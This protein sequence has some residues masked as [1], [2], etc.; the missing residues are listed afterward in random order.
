MSPAILLLAFGVLLQAKPD[1]VTLVPGE[2]TEKIWPVSGSADFPDKTVLQI[3][4]RR[5]ERRWEEGAT[6]PLREIPAETW[7]ARGLA[8][9]IR[10]S[11]QVRLKASTPGWYE[12]AVSR[13][14][15]RIASRLV[16]MGRVDRLFSTTR[17][18]DNAI[19]SVA[20]QTGR[21]LDE[22]ERY[23]KTNTTPPAKAQEDFF[24]RLAAQEQL[25]AVLAAETDLPATITRLQFVLSLLRNA[26]VWG[27]GRGGET[28]E[29]GANDGKSEGSAFHTAKVS[30]D[31]ARAIVTSTRKV[32]SLELRAS[33][34]T[35]LG[36]LILR[37]NTGTKGAER[38][39]LA[40]TEATRLLGE[41]PQPEESFVTLLRA[42]SQ[43]K[44]E[45]LE[46][47]RKSLEI[48]LA[49]ILVTLP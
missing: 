31:E 14:E 11:Y 42:L 8:E 38:L 47:I 16:A 46:G 22:L 13:G 2:P 25:L 18:Q 28:G 43:A 27:G 7:S 41:A 9:V 3:T 37:V 29:A 17:D 45:E 1:P 40:A 21:F 33:S 48:H 20:E 49:T 44:P 10:K 35:L 12:L 4:A 26:N 23:T 15:E 36:D 24:L 5:I 30:L 6:V 39:T 32:L 19:L 34:A